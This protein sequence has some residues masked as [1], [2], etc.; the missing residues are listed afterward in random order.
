MKIIRAYP[1]IYAELTRHFPIKGKAG[2]LYAWGNRIFNPSGFAVPEWLMA[3]ESVHGSRQWTMKDEP[4]GTAV[5]EA[6]VL[7][8]WQRYIHDHS[9]R[10]AEEVPAHQAE[11][12]SINALHIEEDKKERYLAAMA[13][14]LSGPLYNH[15]IGTPEATDLILGGQS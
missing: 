12:R 7:S 2:I 8:W 5:L 13:M 3:H 6:E 9:F 4:E 15:M 14:R 10:L 11:W 1:P